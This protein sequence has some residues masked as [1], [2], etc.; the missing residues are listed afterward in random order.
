MCGIA[1]FTHSKGPGPS[2][3][4]Q[5]AITSIIHRGPDQQGCFESDHISLGAT[6]LKIIDLGGG[7][8][9]ILSQNKDVVIAFNGEIYNHEEIRHELEQRGHRFRSHCDTETVLQAFL[10][11]DTACF[12]RM[13][14]MFAI[15][16]WTE[17][18]NRLV[19]ARDRV[20]IKPLYIC[21][22]GADIVFGSEM[23]TIF[24]HPD[25]ERRLNLAALDCYLALNY[26]P[27][28]LTLVEGIEKMQ[29][30]TWLEWRNGAVRTESFW[31]LPFANTQPCALDSAAEQLDELLRKSIREHLVSDVP[32]G[33]WLSGGL[34]SSTILHY[35]AAAS[36]SPIRTFSISF[37]GRTFDDGGY[38]RQV[39]SHY[40]TRHEQLN[41]TEDAGLRD[42]IEEFSYYADDPNADAG[43]LP[44][45][46]LSK[47][48]RQRVT[49][50]LSGE[51][52]DE[53]FGGYLTYR[54]DELSKP[55]RKAPKPFLGLAST[56]AARM[57]PISDDKISFEYKLKRFLEGCKM[58]AERAHV[59]WNGTF[60]DA[61]K[62]E[63]VDKPTPAGLGRLMDELRTAGAD[64]KGFL[65]FDQKYFLSDDILAKVDRISMAHSLELRP[66][67]LDHRIIEF[68]A[69]LPSHLQMKGSRQ[70]LILRHL[71]RGKLP[72]S[73][74]RRKKIG[75]DIPAHEWLRGP[76]RS[77]MTDVL[78]TGMSAYSD[79]FRREA[80]ER[81]MSQHLD[82]T[83]NLGYHLWGLM[84][85]F[86]W[87]QRWNI[88]VAQPEL[89]AVKADYSL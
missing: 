76:L 64:F 28:P 7:D 54:A 42:A 27:A 80:I 10:E 30:G 41:F 71:M 12:D 52:A 32:L 22:L 78:Q 2:G 46:F 53:L 1:G 72:K 70:K 50:A 35:A 51:G 24:A 20:G 83:Q 17:S 25:V 29:P 58:P 19:L 49:V 69:T 62:R 47:M 81:V 66:P 44:V 67:F 75:F 48:T 33:L 74:L 79:V 26:V 3:I 77:F 23:K 14:G 73:I 11:W 84:I 8:Q 59:Y 55:I 40:G 89:A 34:D 31:Q 9:P 16:L 21:R 60:S 88:Q 39:A 18:Q 61:G 56:L 82:R 5:D 87:M 38:S 4:I 68:A 86:L 15:A 6:R 65:W 37:Q 45:W 85:L 36:R 57:M 63:L 13:R 43:A